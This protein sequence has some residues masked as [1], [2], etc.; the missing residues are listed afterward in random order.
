MNQEIDREGGGDSAERQSQL[1]GGGEQGTA[2]VARWSA[3]GPGRHGAGEQMDIGVSYWVVHHCVVRWLNGTVWRGTWPQ[4]NAFCICGMSSLSGMSMFNK[5]ATMEE[6]RHILWD[7]GFPMDVV[8]VELKGLP[9]V[10][11]PS[12]RRS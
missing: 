10:E 7:N 3:Q 5:A 9:A 2:E 1:T 6:V 12:K 8:P 4:M 11:R